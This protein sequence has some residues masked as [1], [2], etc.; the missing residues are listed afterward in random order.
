VGDV[1]IA[2]ADGLKG[3]PEAVSAVF[4]KTKIQTQTC[5][6]HQICNCWDYVGGKDRNRP[7]WKPLPSARGVEI[8]PIAPIWRRHWQEMTLFFACLLE[9]SKVIKNRR[10]YSNDEGGIQVNL[11]RLAKGYEKMEDAAYYLACC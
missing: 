5:I 9:V 7:C 2:V 6:V 11:Y 8:S 10:H 1:L 4:S 3:L